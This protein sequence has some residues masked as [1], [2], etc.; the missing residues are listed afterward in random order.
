MKNIDIKEAN[1]NTIVKKKNKNS[2]RM[3]WLLFNSCHIKVEIS[4]SLYMHLSVPPLTNNCQS[5][6]FVWLRQKLI[7][8][9]FW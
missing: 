4:G 8:W 2:E 5:S 9:E 6:L 3:A 7:R 1:D